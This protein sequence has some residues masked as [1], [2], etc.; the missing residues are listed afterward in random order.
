M[1]TA[2]ADSSDSQCPF[3]EIVSREDPD[4]REVFRDE[5]VVVFFPT[6]PATLGHTMIV[7]R[8]HVASIWDVPPS[9]AAHLGK[10]MVAVAGAVRRAMRP[11][12]LN[13]VQSNGEAATQTVMHVHIHVLPR[14]HDDAVGDLWPAETDYDEAAKDQAWG[15]IRSE[16][17]DLAI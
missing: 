7:P 2:S 3:C 13:I 10:A 15:L 1:P 6:E 14:W 11:D 12:G 17:S 8:A 16:C 4:A 5:H 9:V